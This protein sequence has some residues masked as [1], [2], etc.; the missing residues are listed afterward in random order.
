MTR[1]AIL[2][3][4]TVLFLPSGTRPLLWRLVSWCVFSAVVFVGI[5]WALGL[6]IN[7][8]RDMGVVLATVTPLVLSGMLVTRHFY[9]LQKDLIRTSST[10]SMTGLMNRI[11]FFDA[12]E[13]ASPGALLVIDVD[14]FKSVNDR[15][16]HTVGDT[17]LIA[18]AN[19]LRVNIRESDLLGRI[20]GEEFGIYIVGEDSH[21][22]DR[23]GARICKGRV[24]YDADMMA[25][26]K[27]TMSIGAAY[28]AMSPD[29]PE[30]YRRADEALFQAKRSGRSC[31]NFWQPTFN[32]A[33]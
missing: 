4:L 3:A 10:D 24:V 30:T 20:G 7:L 15:Y 33:R 12:V 2:D 27:V 26:V 18:V 23:I 9:Q 13:R 28:S 32:A 31:L 14:H 21:Y 17:V 6:P 16:G 22:V 5:E 11:A 25:P 19:H 8:R 1:K 29:L